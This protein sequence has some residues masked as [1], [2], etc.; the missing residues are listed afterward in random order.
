[1]IFHNG[2]RYDNHLIIRQISKDFNGYFECTGENTE[3]YIT[4]SMNV[5]KKDTSIKKKRPETFRLRF[6]DS[7]R[8]MGSKLDS[9]V[10]SLA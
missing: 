6:I 5:V 3:K 7:Y 9:I 8:F 1:M 2:S 10:K 4:F